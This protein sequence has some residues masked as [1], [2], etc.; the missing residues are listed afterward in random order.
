MAINR[1]S[2]NHGIRIASALSLGLLLAHAASAAPGYRASMTGHQLVRDMLADPRD[3]YNAIR[4]ERVMGYIDG[5]MDAT[6]G[7]QWCPAGKEVPHEMNYVIAEGMARL[8][9]DRLQS[10]ASP[11]VADQLRRAYPCGAKP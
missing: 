7:L 3:G 6:A 1:Y 4:R 11:L 8:T 10:D 5:V 9:A 2:N